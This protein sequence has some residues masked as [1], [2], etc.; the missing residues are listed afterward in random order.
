MKIEQLISAIA[1]TDGYFKRQAQKQ[2]NV[3]LTLRNWLIGLYIV[4][5]EQNGADRAEYGQKI[6]KEIAQRAEKISGISERNLYLFKSFYLAYPHILQSATA[7]LH[8]PDLQAIGV[9]KNLS[10]Q[11][12]ERQMPEKMGITDANLLINQ[13][14]FTHIIE[15]LKADEPL[16]RRFYEVQC[17]KNSWSVRA[18]Q[19][20]MNSLL[21]ERTGLST[22]KQAVLDKQLNNEVLLPEEVFRNP[23]ILEFLELKEE[24]AYSGAELE[25]AIINHLHSFLL[26]L[27]KGFCFEARQKRITFDNAH[28]HIFLYINKRCQVFQNL[29]PFVRKK[30]LYATA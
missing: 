20:A 9:L 1:Q 21:F 12:E 25:T 29:T 22:D 30:C 2:V 18:L 5:Y 27:G 16:K 19:R 8:L 17:I 10:Q 3:A 23:Y 4:E 15:L 24:T 14:S 26:E 28:Y 13:L 11:L 6:I 7:K